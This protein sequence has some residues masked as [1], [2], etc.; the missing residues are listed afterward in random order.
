MTDT[1]IA[2]LR[3]AGAV[4]VVA[5]DIDG[6][7]ASGGSKINGIVDGKGTATG[8]GYDY[9]AQRAFAANVTQVA[10]ESEEL[11]DVPVVLLVVDRGEERSD[12]KSAFEV[13][14]WTGGYGPQALSEVAG[15]MLGGGE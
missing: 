5:C 13:V 9:D 6:V 2:F 3:H 7:G 11:G 8:M 14:F 15:A 10:R 4:V 12:F 1:H